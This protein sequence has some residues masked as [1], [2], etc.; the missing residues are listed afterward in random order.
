MDVELAEQGGALL[1]HLAGDVVL[2]AHRRDRAEVAE[3]LGDPELVV[4]LSRQRQSRF[5][6]L[7]RE[8][9][10]A[11]AGRDGAACGQAP[12]P[13]R[14]VHLARVRKGGLDPLEAFS[15]I[16]PHLPE[17]TERARLAQRQLRIVLGDQA[18]AAR[19]LSCSGWMRSSHIVMSSPASVRVAKVSAS[20][21]SHS[22]CRRR[23]SSAR[24]PRAAR[25]RSGEPSRA[26]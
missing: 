22:A 26:S 11:E 14:R 10:V 24:P 21:V 4:E 19:M 3:L 7:L 12:E 2:L 6:A 20:S 23:R 15:E 17:E 13:N 18:S 1:E 5:L 8:I 9:E 25:R 16:A